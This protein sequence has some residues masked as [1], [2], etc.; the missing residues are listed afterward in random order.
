MVFAV[1]EM[2][3]WLTPPR[4]AVHVAF[5]N[6]LGTDHK[7]LKSRT[8]E[9]MKFV[10][11]L[12]E[13][14]E[15]AAVA[16]DERNPD[17]GADQRAETVHTIGIGAVKYA[18]LSTDRIKDY[19]F[20]WDR[21]LSFDGNTGP[22]LQYAHA[23]ICSIFRRAGVD[24]ASVRG[25]DIQVGT[26]QERAL[27]LTAARLP[28]GDRHDARDLQPAQVVHLRVR[29]GDRLHR[30]LR[31]LSGAQGRRAVALEPSRSRRSHG[32]DVGAR[33]GPARH[34]CPGADVTLTSPPPAQPSR[35]RADS[36]GTGHPNPYTNVRRAGPARLWC[37]L[38]G[39][40][41]PNPYTNVRGVRA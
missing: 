30:V 7:M 9:S 19:V 21:M 40:G 5:G 18:E 38:G 16:I 11:L 15:R 20:D 3:G 34:R 2:A 22:Y 24:R 13:A 36:G 27:A 23:R 12:D 39:T 6:V 29:P 35:L 14:L 17:L 31:A 41:H 4:E 28:D 37:D 1:A 32:P 10:E 25:V 8:G 33:A 26:P